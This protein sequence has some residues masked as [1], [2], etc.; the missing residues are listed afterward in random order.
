[1]AKFLSKRELLN[2]TKGFIIFQEKIN[3]QKIIS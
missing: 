1:M 3:R 2:T